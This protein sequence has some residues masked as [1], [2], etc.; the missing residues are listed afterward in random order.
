MVL[1]VGKSKIRQLQLGRAMCHNMT[2]KVK[3]HMGCDG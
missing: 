2:E 1:E 3:G